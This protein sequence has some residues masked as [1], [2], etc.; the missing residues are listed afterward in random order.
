M[1]TAVLLS[2]P[3]PKNPSPPAS[4]LDPCITT[5]HTCLHSAPTAP[6]A[7]FSPFELAFTMAST[8]H[9]PV[10][11]HPLAALAAQVTGSAS[12]A[13]RIPGCSSRRP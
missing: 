5:T 3:F 12:D 9:L 8:H 2:P 6:T 10:L 11:H 13:S 4:S 7:K 1:P